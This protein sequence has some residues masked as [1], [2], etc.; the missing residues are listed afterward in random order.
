MKREDIEYNEMVDSFS[1]N[2]RSLNYFVMKH[3]QKECNEN[4]VLFDSINNS[5]VNQF[6][7]FEQ[8]QLNVIKDGPTTNVIVSGKRSFEAARNYCVLGKKVAVLNFANNHHVGG[9]PFSAGAQE[10]S[11]CRTSTLYECLLDKYDSF[12]QYHQKLFDDG[13]IN[14][15]GNDDL[16]YSPNIIVFKTDESAPKMMDENDWFKVDIITCA[17]PEYRRSFNGSESDWANKGGLKRLRKVFEVAKKQ[18]ANVLVLGAWGCGAFGNPT[19]EVAKAFKQLCNEYHFE[20]IEFAID[21][22]RGLTTNFDV[23]SEVFNSH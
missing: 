5:K 21:C 23:F 6:I 4:A 2:Y 13:I 19:I 7:V 12:Y 15:W 14:N 3:T 1:S 17:A 22:S 16:I 20:T 10:E 11:L 9:A 18:G 8:D